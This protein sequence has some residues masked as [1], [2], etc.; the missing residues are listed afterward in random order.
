MVNSWV[1][2]VIL[3][4]GLN[5]L[6]G[7]L[8]RQHA[9]PMPTSRAQQPHCMRV[10]SESLHLRCC[11]CR[12]RSIVSCR[13]LFY[14]RLTRRSRPQA[15]CETLSRRSGLT[16]LNVS[17]HLSSNALG[18]RTLRA[19]YPNAHLLPLQRLLVGPQ[20]SSVATV[21]PTHRP[22][23]HSVPP[24]CSLTART[25]TKSIQ[26]LTHTLQTLTCGTNHFPTC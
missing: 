16:S 10:M 7:S 18:Q 11:C 22:N 1:V 5:R 15:F 3:C 2:L 24:K 8:P 6:A 23:A 4:G 26:K 20:C 19:L 21:T 25:L 17:A 14:N 13:V 12:R 9:Q